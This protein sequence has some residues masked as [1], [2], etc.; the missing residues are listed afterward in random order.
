MVV[1]YFILIYPI[2]V[3][4]SLYAQLIKH[5]AMKADGGVNII[6]PSF[7]DLGTRWR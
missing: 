7:L 5:Y 6:E 4:L 1:S 2:K 3:K